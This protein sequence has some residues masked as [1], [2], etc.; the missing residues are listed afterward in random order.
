MTKTTHADL[1]GAILAWLQLTHPTGLF[2]KTNTGAFAGEHN[3]RKRFIRFGTPGLADI[4]GILPGGRAIYVECKVG[5]DTQSTKQMV[6]Q[7]CVM[8]AGGRYVLARSIEDVEHA[9]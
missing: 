9:L 2:Y 7:G 6:F 1:V 4:T 5:R 3:G 8:S